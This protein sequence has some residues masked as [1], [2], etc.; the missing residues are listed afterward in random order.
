M[1]DTE[2]SDRTLSPWWDTGQ[3]FLFFFAVF[4]WPPVHEVCPN[5]KVVVFQPWTL[6]TPH[7]GSCRLTLHF[8]LALLPHLSLLFFL[9]HLFPPFPYRLHI[10]SM[11]LSNT[12]C[13]TCP[14]QPLLVQSAACLGVALI[15]HPPASSACPCALRSVPTYAAFP[16]S[17]RSLLCLPHPEPRYLSSPGVLPITGPYASLCP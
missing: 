11:S 5:Y 14:P 7:L 16:V 15:R 10:R 6:N 13:F 4:F 3:Y 8:N 17:V 9:E 1:K 12:S 2:I